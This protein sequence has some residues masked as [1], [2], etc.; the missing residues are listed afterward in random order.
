MPP[1]RRTRWLLLVAAVGAAQVAALLHWLAGF[2]AQ[3]GEDFDV[4]WAAARLLATGHRGAMYSLPDQLAAVHA[5]GGV[6]VTWLNHAGWGP[7]GLASVLPFSFMPLPVAVALW[8]VA[9]GVALAL[10]VVLAVGD[11]ALLRRHR[12]AVVLAALATPGL[13]ALVALGQWE[14]FAALLLVLAWRDM[15]AGRRGRSALWLLLL[16]G[17]LPP[18][19]I[20]L[21]GYQA[22]RWGWPQVRRLAAGGLALGAGSLLLLGPGGVAG[23]IGQVL[24]L[25]RSV[26]PGDTD[27]VFGVAGVLGSG[28]LV[29]VA[30]GLA[31]AAAITACWVLGRRAALFAGDS[32]GPRAVLTALAVSTLSLVASPHLFDYTACALAPLVV[33]ALVRGRDRAQV[34]ALG[35]L[36]AGLG[37][38]SVLGLHQGHVAWRVAV[39]VGLVALA[40]A[41]TAAV[42]RDEVPVL[43]VRRMAEPARHAEVSAA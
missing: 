27:G 14:G 29:T 39:P 26:R 19:A 6:G 16:A 23:W 2:G 30:G 31:A 8:T 12:R 11:G 34:R 25:G 33:A 36:W 20:G 24:D 37:L 28:P 4:H 5:A 42:L 9:Q 17:A 13:A 3:V 22:A 38:C 15:G 43:R 40:V 41:T 10:A 18:V 21:L 35:L 1:P 32:A 7:V